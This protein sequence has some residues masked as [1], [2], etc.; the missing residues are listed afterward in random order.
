[1][2]SNSSKRIVI[3][4]ITFLLF[5]VATHAQDKA[6][7][8]YAWK[9]P[10]NWKGGNFTVPPWFAEDLNLHGREILHFHPD[11]YNYG[12]E[13]FWTYNFAL[14]VTETKTPTTQEIIEETRLYFVGL[15]RTL[16]DRKNPN[17]PISDITVKSTSKWV[18]KGN[19]RYQ[20]YLLR[21]FDSWETGKAINLNVRVTT[22]LCPDKK[23]RVVIYSVSPKSMS[24]KIWKEL[25]ADADGFKCLK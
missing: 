17:L 14:I 1:M 16:G 15:G 9:S 4:I 7:I 12:T 23:H 11:Y 20:D 2:T 19:T 5:S 21:G 3:T 22:W 10:L 18:I 6:D 24:D 8:S 13:G 25:K